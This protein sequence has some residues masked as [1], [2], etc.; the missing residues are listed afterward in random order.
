[1][2]LK[3]RILSVAA[4]LLGTAAICFGAAG[5]LRPLEDEER[6]TWFGSADRETIYFWYTDE[7]M[8][9]FINSAAVDFGE[10]RDVRVIPVLTSESEYLE[11]VNQASLHTDRIPDL[12]LMGNDSLEKAYLAGL[13]VETS[14][15]GSV[16]NADNFPQVALN[17]V[18]YHG[19][20]IAYPL[21]FETTAL[22]YNESYLTEWA[23]Q[24]A[25]R[26]LTAE[27]AEDAENAVEEGRE[28]SDEEIARAQEILL[29][30]VP[31]TLDRLLNIANTFDVPEGVEIMKWDVSDISCNYWIVG[32]YLIVG[33]ASGDDK[34]LIDIDNE[35]TVECLRV[36]Q[37]LN[38]F[39][40]MESDTI[41]YDSVIQDFID[42]KIMFTVA[43]T[44][45]IRRLE[46]AKQDGTFVHEYGIATMPDISDGSGIVAVPEISGRLDSAS[47]SVTGAVVV[48]GYSE[49]RELA[50][51]FA[52]W[53]VK[54]R[55]EEL[56]ERTGKLPA[57]IDTD[58]DNG[59]AQI[60]KLEY[61][62]SVSLPK[63]METGNFRL[64]MEVLFSKVWGGADVETQVSELAG[65]IATQVTPE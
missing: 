52:A 60:F 56:Y 36:Y 59:P 51:D 42:G 39:F 17:A 7:S 3:N 8:T 12:Y 27:N 54:D 14:D 65:Q 47:L 15:G 57:L 63:L 6:N 49:H 40:S 13:A 23:L 43:T 34:T 45:V 30:G 64:Q 28:Y 38:Q 35:R 25:R 20:N 21:Y 46:T 41:T 44:D 4:L 62:D 32:R 26:E 33:G 61:A 5:E 11:A 9:G 50:N 24:Q 48:N 55:A 31:E 29:N 37:A 22:V 18:S 16:C 53:L 2:Q 10:E 58:A 1:M 19:K